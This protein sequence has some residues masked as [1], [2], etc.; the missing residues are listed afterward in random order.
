MIVWSLLLAIML[1]PMGGLSLDLWHGIAVQRSLQAAA[2]DAATAGASGIDVQYYRDTGCLVLDPAAA[3][4]LAQANLAS[5]AGL[6]P[7]AAV[8]ISVSPGGQQ[9]SV[10]L[11]EDVHL[12]LLSLVE[13]DRPLVVAA[14]AWSSPKGSVLASGCS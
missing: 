3:V 9:I 10:V 12:T 11:E 2:D 8:D 13:G 5:Q 4:P 6:G 1:L 14:T 7:L